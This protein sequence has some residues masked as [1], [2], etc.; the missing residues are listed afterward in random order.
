MAGWA[1]VG[2]LLIDNLALRP[3]TAEQAADLLEVIE[4][5][6]QLRSTDVTSRCLT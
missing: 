6:C 5:R 1:K 3:L 2:V 4:D